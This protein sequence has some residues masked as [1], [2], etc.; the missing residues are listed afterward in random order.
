MRCGKCGSLLLL[1]DWFGGPSNDEIEN[2]KQ[3]CKKL[4]NWFEKNTFN[5][6]LDMNDFA[7]PY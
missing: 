3:R 2:H 5:R 6:K 4:T 7:E 1:Y